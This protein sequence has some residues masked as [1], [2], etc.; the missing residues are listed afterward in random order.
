[1][2][3]L[4]LGALVLAIVGFAVASTDGDTDVDDVEI[5]LSHMPLT[6]Y[7]GLQ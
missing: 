4:L 6:Y 1:M 5:V 7:G 3:R 2:K